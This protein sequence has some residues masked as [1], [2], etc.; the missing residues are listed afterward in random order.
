MPAAVDQLDAVAVRI[1]DEA[2]Q[3]AALAHAVGL[4]FGL[5]ALLL[6]LRERLLEVVDAD[7]DVAVAGA[8]VVGAAVV[9]ERQLEH[10]LLVAD[11][12]EVVRRLELAVADD[13]HVALE[14]EAERLVEGAA[15][16]RIR[17]PDHRVEEVS[18]ARI[19]RRSGLVASH[20]GEER[21]LRRGDPALP[22]PGPRRT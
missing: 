21:A 13:V 2:D 7:R 3:R 22:P 9:V 6:Q 1:L 15:L 12:E 5:D 16:L 14:A 20:L 4:A 18:H 19:L 11:A 8:E 17:D 10:R